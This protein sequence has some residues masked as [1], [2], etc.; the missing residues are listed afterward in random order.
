MNNNRRWL[1]LAVSIVINLCIG[2]AYAWSV[3]SK[4]LM[5]DFGWTASQASMAFT[6]N[7]FVLPIAMIFAGPLVKR[8]GV[9]VVVLLGGVLFGLG[10]YL[11]GMITT[12]YQIYI[13]YGLIAGSGIGLIYSITVSNTV[14]WFPEHKG[15]AGGLTAGGFGAGSLIFAPVAVQFIAA[16]G[17]L[18]AFQTLGLI[19]A[20]VILV[21]GIFIAAP[22][23]PETDNKATAAATSQSNNDVTTRDM[24]KTADFYMIWG[25]MVLGCIS[26][27]MIISQA[28]PIGQVMVGLSPEQAAFAVGFIGLANATGRVVWRTIS[29]KIGRY[30]T[31]ICMFALSGVGLV[32]LYFTKDLP[33]F[34]VGICLIAASYGGVF[35]L[36]PSITADNFGIKHLSMNYGV[37]MT[38]LSI[39]A[40]IGPQIA[41]YAVEQSGGSYNLAFVITLG[42]NIVAVILVLFAKRM[43]AKH[44]MTLAT[45]N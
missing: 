18:G 21:L 10:L 6:I 8:F 2:F 3:F 41:A 38:G 29:D 25:L 32:A 30:N 42:I 43:N 28:S 16:Q 22:P 13:T 34:M 44:R 31:L 1:I 12:V 7:L 33:L 27:L 23:V 20:G 39:G 14:K 37:V 26:G 36:F 11:S 15:L 9:R 24:L 5:V 45:E 40:F 17:V 4:P 35:G 19:F